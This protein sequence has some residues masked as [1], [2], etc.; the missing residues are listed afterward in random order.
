M[1]MFSFMYSRLR[2]GNYIWTVNGLGPSGHP[3]IYARDT[4]GQLNRWHFMHCLHYLTVPRK[5]LGG[6]DGLVA[7][8]TTVFN[9]W[10]QVMIP[11][12][13][14]FLNLASSATKICYRREPR[15]GYLSLSPI[16]KWTAV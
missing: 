8:L 13:E 1:D 4:I 3:S 12:Y 11:F 9:F 2:D 6:D 7:L 15:G 14:I 5:L 16:Q 10:D